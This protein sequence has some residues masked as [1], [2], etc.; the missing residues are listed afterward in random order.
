VY[1]YPSKRIPH[2]TSHT[3]QNTFPTPLS[4]NL[5]SSDIQSTAE[6]HV[7]KIFRPIFLLNSELCMTDKNPTQKILK[8]Q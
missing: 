6:S 7:A 5:C 2:L 4:Y 3:Q 8:K 1:S